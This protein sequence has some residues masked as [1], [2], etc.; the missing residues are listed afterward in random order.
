MDYLGISIIDIIR[1]FQSSSGFQ[2]AL[3]LDIV[4]LGK[5][6]DLFWHVNYP[7]FLEIQGGRQL[8]L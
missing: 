8:R 6:S 4:E 1:E 3:S 5:G 7:G 2:V